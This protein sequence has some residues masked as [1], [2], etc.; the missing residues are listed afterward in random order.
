RRWKKETQKDPFLDPKAKDDVEDLVQNLEH[1][2]HK[3]E[4]STEPEPKD[5]QENTAIPAEDNKSGTLIVSEPPSTTKCPSE[6]KFSKTYLHKT[7]FEEYKLIASEILNE[8]EKTL[9]MYAQ[10]GTAFPVGLLNLM[11]YSWQ[12][13]IEDYFKD[14]PPKEMVGRDRNSGGGPTSMT[15]LKFKEGKVNPDAKEHPQEESQLVKASKCSR[16][17]LN[18]SS[19]RAHSLNNTHI[20]HQTTQGSSIPGI[21]H[22]SLTSKLCF[23]N[24]WIPC[25]K[26]EIMKLKA[27][28][29]K[30]VKRLQTTTVQM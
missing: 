2:S 18:K 24:G 21:I 27:D 6:S 30:A 4:P 12:D 25:T 28:L 8:L 22:F 26:L 23:K 17:E 14:E 9:K 11:T 5:A 10:D 20:S 7:L 13:L 16:V 15:I 19:E 1:L 3:L 29:S